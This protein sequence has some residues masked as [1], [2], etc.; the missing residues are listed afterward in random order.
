MTKYTVETNNKI[1]I[2]SKRKIAICISDEQVEVAILAIGASFFTCEYSKDFYFIEATFEQIEEIKDFDFIVFV[3]EYKEIYFKTT[4]K[5]QEMK[6]LFD[7][8]ENTI[9]KVEVDYKEFDKTLDDIQMVLDTL[10][11]E[12]D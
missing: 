3:E 9:E 12:R 7:T 6:Y 11:N 8:L 4:S 10:K 2:G 5:I 1:T